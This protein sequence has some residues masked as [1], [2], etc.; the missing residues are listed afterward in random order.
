[1]P[2]S[3]RNPNAV[4]T[5]KCAGPGCRN[6]TSNAD[7]WFITVIEEESFFCRRYSASCPLHRLEQPVCGQACAVRLFDRFLT[8]ANV[9]C[10][11]N[12]CSIGNHSTVRKA[13]PTR[14]RK[15]HSKQSLS[16]PS[17]VRKKLDA[18]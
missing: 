15:R 10:C 8:Y 17:G 7:R 1:M 12:P 4:N 2:N 9:A 14:H 11:T 6:T 3:S 5:I 18:Q 16:Q 13:L